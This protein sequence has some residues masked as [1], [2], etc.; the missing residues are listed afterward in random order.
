MIY[1]INFTSTALSWWQSSISG[2]DFINTKL[3]FKV[4]QQNQQIQYKE[5][6]GLP[7]RNT[8]PNK[9]KHKYYL[10]CCHSLEITKIYKE[11]DIQDYNTPTALQTA[12]LHFFPIGTSL[13]QA[14]NQL[15]NIHEEEF[16]SE[17]A[18]EI[19]PSIYAY[20]Y[21]RSLFSTDRTLSFSYKNN[22]LTEINVVNQRT[23]LSFFP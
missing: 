3:I 10:S 22:Q 1:I 4:N 5:L 11:L 15:I 21:E 7:L 23:D 6:Y 14:H 18:K 2:I 8:H 19:Q 17:L 9:V 13:E 16:F 12:L 20:S